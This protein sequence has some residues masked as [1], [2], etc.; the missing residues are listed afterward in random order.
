MNG[1]LTRQSLGGALVLFTLLSGLFWARHLLWPLPAEAAVANPLPLGRLIDGM[2]HGI[3]WVHAAVSS[4][5]IYMTAI[6]VTRLVSRNLVFQVRTHAFLPLLVVA[7]FGIF[8]REGN[9]A[10]VVAMY[11]LARGSYYF[12]SAYRRRARVG[13]LFGGGLMF[14]LAPLFHAPSVVYMVMVIVAMPIYRRNFRETA[15]ALIG[16]LLPALTWFYILW[17]TDGEPMWPEMNYVLPGMDIMR[18]VAAGL[19]VATVLISLVSFM[20]DA[21]KIRTRAYHI[22]LY[23]LCFLA[24]GLAGWRS[25]GDL[26]MVAVPVSVVAA[27]WFSRHE[28]LAPTIVYT[29]TL[30]AAI[31]VNVWGI[32]H[33]L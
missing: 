30:I 2:A 12:A 21:R 28:G 9:S 23:M 22:H 31:S 3:E 11:L 18:M 7:G 20:H 15:L 26:P 6:C 32:Y 33:S 14:G 4:V 13:D 25:V 16:A 29:L 10:A 1:N 24:V 8:I 17:A 27:S 5:F 19:V